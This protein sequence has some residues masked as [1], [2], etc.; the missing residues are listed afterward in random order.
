MIDM[1]KV[2]RVEVRYLDAEDQELRCLTVHG[3][4]MDLSDRIV[5]SMPG[6]W[7][8]DL[9]FHDCWYMAIDQGHVDVRRKD[10]GAIAPAEKERQ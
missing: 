7:C 3:K 1:S 10:H 2:R 5:S 9:H 6:H 4:N 8:V